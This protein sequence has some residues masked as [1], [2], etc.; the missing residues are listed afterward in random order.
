MHTFLQTHCKVPYVMQVHKN[1]K[2]SSSEKR[3]PGYFASY[4]LPPPATLSSTKKEK[5]ST[6]NPVYHTIKR[7]RN[8]GW[9]VRAGKRRRR[10]ESKSKKKGEEKM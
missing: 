2:Q 6:K 4:S 1:E 7:G 9:P 5:G 3:C 10:S 8:S